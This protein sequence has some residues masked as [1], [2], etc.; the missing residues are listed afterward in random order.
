[1]AARSGDREAERRPSSRHWPRSGRCRGHRATGRPCRPGRP[2]GAIGRTEVPQGRHRRRARCAIGQ[3]LIS[4][5]C[6][7]H[8]PSLP[9]PPRPSAGGSTPRHGGPSQPGA[10]DPSRPRPSRARSVV[11]GR[12]SAEHGERALADLLGPFRP[13]GR[14]ETAV[15][16][17]LDIPTFTDDAERRGLAFTFDNGRSDLYQLPETFGG[18]VAVLDFDGDGWLDVY[19]VRADR[20]RPHRAPRASATASSA[21]AAT[22]SSMTSPPGPDWRAQGRLRVRGR[23]GRL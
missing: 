19:A 8:P 9:A 18:G 7:P 21:T 20:S 10:I 22:V 3:L 23:R 12:A 14:A 15:T 16:G 6:A 5:N 11:H 2:A 1:M 17:T 4:P 13:P